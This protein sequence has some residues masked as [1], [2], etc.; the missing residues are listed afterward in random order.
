MI[1]NSFVIID[2]SVLHHA[3]SIKG[4]QIEYRTNMTLEKLTLQRFGEDVRDVSLRGNMTYLN[5][6]VAY[7]LY[8]A[9]V[10]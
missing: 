8:G 2:H 10:A 7:S 9:H 3:P 1:D 5:D 6:L 4:R